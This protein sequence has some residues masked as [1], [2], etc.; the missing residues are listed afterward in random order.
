[1]LTIS[2][3][4]W[5]DES[6]QRSYSFTHDHVR[7]LK[8]MVERNLAVPHRFVCVTDDEI[9]GIE[10]V[11]LDWSKHVPGTCF[12]RLMQRRPD[13]AEIIGGDR[14]LNLDLDMVIVGDIAPLIDRTEENVFWRNPNWPAPRRAYYQTSVQLLTPGTLAGLYTE[15]DP[16]TSP[17]LATRRFGGAEQA[18]ISERLPW[19]SWRSQDGIGT[20]DHRD[21]IYGAGRIGDWQSEARVELPE[22]ARIVSFPGNRIPDQPE[23]MKKF[24]WVAEHYR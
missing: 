21:G 23:V 20:W 8:A 1:M 18:W 3:Y 15:F 10:T 13:Y 2:T 9:D 11:P 14:V 16:A 24:P 19:I 4:Y 5:H 17:A 7:I 6:R 22:N 12:V